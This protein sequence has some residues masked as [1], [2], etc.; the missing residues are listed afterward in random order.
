MH[1]ESAHELHPGNSTGTPSAF[2]AILIPKGDRLIIYG[3]NATVGDGD[4]KNV[5][6][7][8]IQDCLFTLAPYS[9]VRHPILLPNG[10]WNVDVWPQLF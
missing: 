8:V 7:K 10:F 4:A 5:A 6:G 3:H 1:E 2:F 9:A